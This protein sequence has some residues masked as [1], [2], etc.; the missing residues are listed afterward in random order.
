M[1]MWKFSPPKQWEDWSCWLLGFWLFLSPWILSF[2]NDPIAT[3]NAVIIGF[4]LVLVE[5]V[6]LVSFRAWE[7]LANIAIG[8][9][10]IAS[11]FVFGMTRGAA[12]VNFICIGALVI[13]LALFELWQIRQ[14]QLRDT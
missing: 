3:R 2:D 12:T 5:G 11:P 8:V 9:W 6:T 13:V 1:A 4:L 7:E 10:L 14:N